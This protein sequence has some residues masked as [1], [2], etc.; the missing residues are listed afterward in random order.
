MRF[1]LRLARTIAEGK[2]LHGPKGKLWAVENSA[3]VEP[4][5]QQIGA[6]LF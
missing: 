5:V 4:D 3:D 1:G 2:T 6:R